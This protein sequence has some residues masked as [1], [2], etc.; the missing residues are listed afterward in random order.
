[1]AAWH[2]GV[3]AVDAP[4]E[5]VA[6]WSTDPRA[7]VPGLPDVAPGTPLPTCLATWRRGRVLFDGGA[8]ERARLG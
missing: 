8:L 6:R 3:L 4:D 1:M 2:A 5:R 7:A